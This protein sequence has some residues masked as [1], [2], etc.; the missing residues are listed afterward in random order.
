VT[1]RSLHACFSEQGLDLTDCQAM[2]RLDGLWRVM[3]RWVGHK[4]ILTGLS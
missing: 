3:A 4:K 1:V 2:S